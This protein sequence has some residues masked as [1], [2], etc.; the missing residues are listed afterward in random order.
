[1]EVGGC[2]ELVEVVML[3]EAMM[4]VEVVLG[5]VAVLVEAVVPVEVV[6]LGRLSVAVV[7]VREVT[8]CADV[9]LTDAAEDTEL[10][11][12][13]IV[14]VDDTLA[15]HLGGKGTGSGIMER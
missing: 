9:V 7:A 14:A 12:G 3:V 5:E 15:G 13:D 6:V 10:V 11:V 1:M 4:L 8:D 2:E